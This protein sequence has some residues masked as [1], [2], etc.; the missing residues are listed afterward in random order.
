ME[1]NIL[2]EDKSNKCKLLK[3][4][5]INWLYWNNGKHVLTQQQTKGTKQRCKSII[6]K[7]EKQQEMLSIVEDVNKCLL[8]VKLITWS[9]QDGWMRQKETEY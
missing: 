2:I 5:W 4:F 3:W 1:K 7:N 9:I 6:K 8:F